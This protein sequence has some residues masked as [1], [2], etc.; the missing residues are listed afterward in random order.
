MKFTIALFIFCCSLFAYAQSNPHLIMVNGIAERSVDPNM[1]VLR[2]ESWGKAP[3]AK[4]AQEIQAAQYQKL[5]A[6]TEKFKIKK[7]D[8]Q[9]EN[10]SISPDY[11]YDQKTQNNK[12]V[13]YRVSHQISLTYRKTEEAGALIDALSTSAK[14]DNGGVSIQ[15]IGWDFDKKNVVE[16][17]ALADAVKSA[18]AKAE[19]LAKAAGVRIK[20]VH[21]IQHSSHSAPPPARPMAEMSMKA[22]DSSA[23]T[24]VSSGQIKIRVEVQME[25]EI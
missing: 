12:I 3:T 24:E 1:T 14:A 7:E 18:R 16:V 20:A 17:G 5:K 2:I 4:V 19:D 8:V 10:F 22:M 21:R 13:G 6:V 25:F 15:S 23:S 9:T 11:F